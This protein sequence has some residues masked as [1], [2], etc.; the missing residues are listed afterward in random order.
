MGVREGWG[1]GVGGLGEGI[2][3][4]ESLNYLQGSRRDQKI[5]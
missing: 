2:L 3:G 4:T 1:G 5:K